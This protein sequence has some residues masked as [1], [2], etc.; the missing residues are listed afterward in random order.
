MKD[1]P[2]DFIFNAWPSENPCCVLQSG[3]RRGYNQLC[4]HDLV[5]VKGKSSTGY[6]PGKI[7]SSRFDS[8]INT[9]IY[10]V[11]VN[12]VVSTKAPEDFLYV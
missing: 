4:V 9:W 6:V 11:Q 1:F 10:S 3:G 7:T 8:R 12:G 2:K 5:L